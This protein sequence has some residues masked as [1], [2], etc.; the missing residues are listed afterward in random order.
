MIPVA[1]LALT[2]LLAPFPWGSVLP[3]G[4]VRIEVLAFA[5]LIATALTTPLPFR[6]VRIPIIGICLIALLGVLQL[7]PLGETLVRAL[8]PV[9]AA[10][11]HNTAEILA[12][13][14]RKDIP[15]AKISIAPRETLSAIALTLAYGAL[16]YC[17]F[18][19]LRE[20][21]SRWFFAAIVVLAA[22][23]QIVIGVSNDSLSERM[24]ASFV[25]PNHLAGYLEIALGVSFALLWGRIATR[26]DRGAGIRDRATRLERQYLPIVPFIIL[27]GFVAGGLAL[28]RSRGGVAA[29]LAATILCVILATA[30]RGQ[31]EREQRWI[32]PLTVGAIGLGITFVMMATGASALAR[33]HGSVPEIGGDFR[34]RIWRLSLDAW[35]EFPIFGSG[36]GAFREAFRRI[37]PADFKGM[38]E[39]AHNDFLQLLVSGGII[40]GLLGVIT[41]GSVLLLLLRAWRAQRHREERALALGALGA[42]A[43]LIIHGVVEFNLAVPAISAT[44]AM[45]AGWGL[46]AATARRTDLR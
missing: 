17:A 35:R 19:A 34:V 26:R 18:A 46:A 44:L 29:A 36:L 22:V 30:S 16:F 28:T 14:G 38:L 37:Q 24:H 40:G 25:N 41:V 33:F 11:Y 1:L 43:A 42:L 27:W 7:L 20:R 31:K 13:Y 21:T 12:L 45:V 5:T 10:T 2:V 32:M 3:G 9:S 8:S 6:E 15:T 23:I 39:Y 4:I